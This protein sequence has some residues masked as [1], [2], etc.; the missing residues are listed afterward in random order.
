[1]HSVLLFYKFLVCH[2]SRELAAGDSEIERV[3]EMNDKRRDY[4]DML[5]FYWGL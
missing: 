4:A 1:M 3:I 5:T 2:L